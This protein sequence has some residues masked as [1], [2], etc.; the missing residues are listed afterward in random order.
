[1]FCVGILANCRAMENGMGVTRWIH[2][3]PR[4]GLRKGIGTMMR[5]R[6]PATSVVQIDQAVVCECFGAADIESSTGGFL[7]FE[8]A[9]E[10]I[11][12]VTDGNGLDGC[13]KP[14]RSE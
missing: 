6:S 12:D 8:T 14:G 4:R 1:M 7:I 3:A 5:L 2:T 11:E 13:S 9:Q 10:V